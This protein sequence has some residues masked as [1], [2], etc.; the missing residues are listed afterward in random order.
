MLTADVSKNYLLK[1][2][3]VLRGL[4]IIRNY[5]CHTC[6]E[7]VRKDITPVDILDTCLENMSRSD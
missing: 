4:R 6:Q 7:V 1:F 2:I 3:Y 5:M